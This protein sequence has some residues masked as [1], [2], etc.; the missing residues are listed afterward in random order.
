MNPQISKLLIRIG[1]ILA[2]ILAW[3][4]LSLWSGYE[5][6][7][8]DDLML[9]SRL[10]EV[11]AALNLYYHDHNQY[12]PLPAG[13]RNS[14]S[15]PDISANCLVSGGFVSRTE[16]RCK[17]GAYLESKPLRRGGALLST[18][19]FTYSPR[20]TD[21]SA[22]TSPVGCPSYEIPLEFKTDAIF[23]KGPSYL[24]PTGLTTSN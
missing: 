12:P 6:A 24:T 20:L 22:C 19:H 5:R 13:I 17:K 15:W 10:A 11:R 21:G 2:I 4:L 16:E 23:Q 9:A 14:L 18:E 1:Y 3:V 8:A 7:R